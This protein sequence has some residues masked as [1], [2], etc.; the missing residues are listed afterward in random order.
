MGG[1]WGVGA[2]LALESRLTAD[3][4]AAVGPAA[5]RLR[6]RQPARGT[7]L[8]H[9]YP[10]AAIH[11][12]GNAWRI[13]FFLGGLPALLSLFIRAKVKESEAWQEHRTDWTAY[14]RSISAA[15]AAFPVSRAPDDDDE[16]HVARD[17]GHVSD[18]PADASATTRRTSRHHD[19]LDGRR[20]ARRAGLRLLLGSRRPPPGDDHGGDAAVCWCC[21]CGWRASAP[22]ASMA[23]VFLMQFF[24]QG[25]WG[26]I[27]A[28]INELSPAAACAA[29]FR[30]SPTSLASCARRRF[31]YI[32][33]WLGE[34]FTYKQSM[35]GLR[36]AG[37]RRRRS[38]S[39]GGV[40][41]PTA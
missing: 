29:S 9:V 32:E 13:M 5:G 41:R 6:D 26:V 23:G 33:S 11:Y 40:R 8:P 35:G 18:A 17:A 12:P 27:P 14:R 20:G 10:G 36:C 4:R 24:V 21:R 2:S 25:A 19:H 39:R 1:E 3:P 38:S 28:H 31:S 30:A 22:C 7:R 37:V 15:M 34:M 16:L